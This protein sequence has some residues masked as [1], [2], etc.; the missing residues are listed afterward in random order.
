MESKWI[1]PESMKFTKSKWTPFA[2]KHVVGKVRRVMLRGEVA[3]IDGEVCQSQFESYAN[4]KFLSIQTDS[5]FIFYISNNMGNLKKMLNSQ[6]TH[7]KFL[8]LMGISVVM[9]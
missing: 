3:Y 7:A 4:L 8:F 2:G 9:V 1:I 6:Y 5:Y